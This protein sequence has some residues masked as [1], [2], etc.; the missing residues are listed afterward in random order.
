[1]LNILYKSVSKEVLYLSPQKI[2]RITNEN[3]KPTCTL[4]KKIQIQ[5]SG[6][7]YVRFF[8]ILTIF[9][10]AGTDCAKID[11]CNLT[12]FCS[13]MSKSDVINIGPDFKIT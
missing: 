5:R 7:L 2:N 4:N 8:C 13:L 6:F 12:I 11:I 3:T 1:M 9:S 10:T